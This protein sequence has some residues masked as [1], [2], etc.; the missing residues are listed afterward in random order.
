MGEC[1]WTDCAG[2]TGDSRM[3]GS[4]EDGGLFRPR[5]LQYQFTRSSSPTT[6]HS[7]TKEVV[8]GGGSRRSVWATAAARARWRQYCEV[9]QRSPAT[10]LPVRWAALGSRHKEAQKGGIAKDRA[11]VVDS[12]GEMLLQRT[13]FVQLRSKGTV[14]EVTYGSIRV[15]YS[16]VCFGKKRREKGV[17]EMGRKTMKSGGRLVDL[18][19]GTGLVK[20]TGRVGPGQRTG[21]KHHKVSTALEPGTSG[22]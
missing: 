5:S 7:E 15:W 19:V 11:A 1:P 12:S 3:K 17:K 9:A 22:T 21:T 14:F 2:G 18:G 13:S 4:R 8:N 6:S 16:G 20:W 10:D